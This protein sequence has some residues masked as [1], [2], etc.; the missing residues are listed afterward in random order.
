MNTAGEKE[1][2]LIRLTYL[3]T[4]RYTWTKLNIYAYNMISSSISVASYFADDLKKH[5]VKG[6]PSLPRI[7]ESLDFTR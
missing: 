1:T 4:L 6:L 5:L 3:I 7:L 2:I